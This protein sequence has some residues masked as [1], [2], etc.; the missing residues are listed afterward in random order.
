[1]IISIVSRLQI[2]HLVSCEM[3]QEVLEETLESLQAQGLFK[4]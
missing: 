2:T 1:M 4:D 3:S